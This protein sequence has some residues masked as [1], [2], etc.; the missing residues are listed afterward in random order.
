M[1]HMRVDTLDLSS[2]GLAPLV[3]VGDT[4]S[5]RTMIDVDS[6]CSGEGMVTENKPLALRVGIEM[7]EPGGDLGTYLKS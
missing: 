5:Q 1:G 6:L 3:A 4:R 7:G 2:L